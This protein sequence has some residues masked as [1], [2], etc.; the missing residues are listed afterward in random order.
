VPFGYFLGPSWEFFSMSLALGAN[1]SYFTMSGDSLAFTDE[2]L[3]LA[4]VVG[5]LEFARFEIADWRFF[6]TY[7]LYS[8]LQLWFISSDVEAGTLARISFGFRIG[9]F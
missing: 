4:A 6:N 2:G 1:I 3:V 5:Q 9:L 8:E 7:S